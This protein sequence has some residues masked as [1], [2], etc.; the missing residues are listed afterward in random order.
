MKKADVLRPDLGCGIEIHGGRAIAGQHEGGTA[1]GRKRARLPPDGAVEIDGRGASEREGD[2]AVFA[3]RGGLAVRGHGDRTAAER[4]GEH[5]ARDGNAADGR[6]AAGARL[7]IAGV[8][9][10]VIVA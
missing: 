7:D 1:D 9:G 4:A 2:D 10:H 8:D 3:G 5:A 6:E